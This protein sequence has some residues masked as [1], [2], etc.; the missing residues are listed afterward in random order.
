MRTFALGRRILV[1]CLAASLVGGAMSIALGVCGPFTD[2][3]DAGFCPFVLEIFTL[4][5][6]TGTTPTTYD[7]TASVSRLQMAA[8]LS[9]TVDGVLKRGSRRAAIDRFWT[10]Q[11]PSVLGLTTVG[12]GPALARFDGADVWVAVFSGSVA[13]VRAKDGKLL[14]TWSGASNAY[15]VLVAMGRVFATGYLD[16]GRLYMIDP[17][18]PAG[19]VTTVASNVGAFPSGVA[20]D[21]ARIWTA[22]FAGSL[23]I[24]TPGATPPWTV[25][26]VTT[27]FLNL[28][29]ALYDGS[30]IWATDNGANTLLKVDTAGTILQ[31]VTVSPGP[32]NAVFDGGNI[33]VPAGDGI[34]SSAVTVVRASSGSVLATLTGNGLGFPIAAAFDGER[35]LV[36]N[37]SGDSVSLWK[38]ADL[39]P[40]GSFSTGTSSQP[41]GVCSDG[42]SFWV[43]LNSGF[44]L[45]RF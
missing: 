9:R 29:G 25:M 33:W 31:T 32:L 20:F 42:I 19:A 27:G 11:D 44:A 8:F 21:G 23:S 13:R 12:I 37:N 38:A 16:P 3:T 36:T 24:V 14:E 35:V 6:T 10:P 28:A 22:N 26:T 39:T 17:S 34:S 1:S 2:V 5:I 4:G 18:Q 41:I 15:G 45:A 40:L 43:G 30:N 7:P